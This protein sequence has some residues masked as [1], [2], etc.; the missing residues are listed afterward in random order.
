VILASVVLVVNAAVYTSAIAE[1]ATRKDAMAS[2]VEHY[3][4]VPGTIYWDVSA[5]FKFDLTFDQMLAVRQRM[6][7]SNLS[8]NDIPEGAGAVTLV[9]FSK[10]GYSCV[11]VIPG[12]VQLMLRGPG[13]P[14]C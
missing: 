5:R 12:G 11:S 1:H 2:R 7:T 10:D 3:D 13:K 14:Q 8:E 9:G 4:K 6:P